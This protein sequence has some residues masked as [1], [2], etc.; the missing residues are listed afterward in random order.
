MPGDDI[1]KKK[2]LRDQFV[3]QAKITRQSRNSGVSL[4]STMKTPNWMKAEKK[5]VTLQNSIKSARKK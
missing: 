1:K 2:E 3:K 5:K 4:D